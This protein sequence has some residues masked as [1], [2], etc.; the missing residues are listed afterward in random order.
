MSE[1]EQNPGAPHQGDADKLR[2]APELKPRQL[3]QLRF[4]DL[5][6]ERALREA[7]T[8][9]IK[10]DLA[11]IRTLYLCH[12]EKTSPTEVDSSDVDDEGLTDADANGVLPA[13]QLATL[14]FQDEIVRK[15][16]FEQPDP[17]SGEP[18]RSIHSIPIAGYVFYRF[19]GQELFFVVTGKFAS[20][21][22]PVLLWLP[23][24]ALVLAIATGFD[25]ERAEKV[26]SQFIGIATRLLDAYLPYIRSPKSKGLALLL[27]TPP[28]AH[29]MWNELPGVQRLLSRGLQD[30]VHRVFACA[31]PVAPIGEI[32]PELA[33]RVSTF[34]T[35]RSIRAIL[36]GHYLA[37]RPGSLDIPASVIERL[38]TVALTR[39]TAGTRSLIDRCDQYP[40]PTLGLTMRVNG[41]RWLSETEGLIHLI[42]R[43]VHEVPDFR[44]IVFGFSIPFDDEGYSAEVLSRLPGILDGERQAFEQMRAACP[45]VEMHALIGEPLLDTL[46]LADRMDF[47]IANHGTIQHKVGWFARCS[48][49]VHANR[50][51]ISHRQGFFATQSACQAAIAPQY[52]PAD[53]VQDR[54]LEGP[55]KGLRHNMHDYDFDWRLLLDPTAQA[56]RAAADRQSGR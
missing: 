6:T 46:A 10:L 5:S 7:Q 52:I 44:V 16:Y 18:C 40:K 48:G 11:R 51:T 25:R 37:V 28:F 41:R 24:R 9:P 55:A 13:W 39:V 43:L 32:F 38:R 54:A 3:T 47:Y 45:T 20:G 4:V 30:K 27:R 1:I 19:T 12:G 49:L 23:Q 21:L 29:H 17:I 33:D 26:L 53:A 22:I 36:N 8:L 31:Q 15:G 56:L 35:Q 50:H 2:G 14:D 42:A 34:R